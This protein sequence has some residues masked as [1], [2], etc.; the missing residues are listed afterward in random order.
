ML[1]KFLLLVILLITTK[2]NSQDIHFSQF[3]NSPQNTNPALAGSFDG[4]LRIAANHKNQWRTIPVPFRTYS[5]SADGK[6]PF[7]LKKDFVCAGLLLNN[8]KS[9]DGAFITNQ[10]GLSLAYLKKLNTD[11]TAFLSFGIQPSF[12]SKSFNLS[13]LSFDNQFSDGNYNSGI[14][15]NENF[16]QTKVNYFDLAAGINYLH[17]FGEHSSASIGFSYSHFQKQNISF[18]SDKSVVTNPKYIAQAS[19]VLGLKD[20]FE[21]IPVGLYQFQNQNREIVAG[22]LARFIFEKRPDKLRAFSL[23]AFLRY[24][25]AFIVDAQLDYNRFRFGLSY[26]IN[27]SG[28]RA[29]SK[30][31]GGFELSLIYIMKRFV[32]VRSNKIICPVFL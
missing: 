5:V 25:D 18:L 9:G 10:I 24:Q 32:R 30:R 21:L 8:D 31:L 29:A 17:K 16:S 19:F 27:I 2:V 7:N 1:K 4:D 11:S 3:Y 20:N 28:L 22:A 26:D 13:K 15:N 14:P 23:G 12:V 6:L